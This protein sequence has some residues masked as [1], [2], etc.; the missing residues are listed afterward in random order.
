ML[1]GGA[2][3]ALSRAGHLGFREHVE[4]SY[5]WMHEAFSMR[6]AME[7]PLPMSAAAFMAMV[8]RENMHLH[9]SLILTLN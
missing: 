7:E 4:R 3:L 6:E 2:V 8:V 9:G 5:E 1:L